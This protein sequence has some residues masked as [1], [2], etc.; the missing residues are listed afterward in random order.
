MTTSEALG[1]I[2]HNCLGQWLHNIAAAKDGRD[3]EGVHQLRIAARRCRSALSLFTEAIGRDARVAWNDRL[4]AVI[5]TTGR[6]RELDVFLTETLPEVARHQT[7]EDEAALAAL[8]R[9]A[10][11]ERA[12]GYTEVRALLDSRAH[13]DLVLDLAIWV[14]LERWRED[15]S[16]DGRQI[17]ESPIIDLARRLLEKRH[18]RVRKLGRHFTR[19]S[20]AER[21]QVRLALKKLR[22]GVE[23]LG[24]L[25][26][27]R[28]AKRYGKAASALQD[29]LGQLN[30]RAETHVLLAGLGSGVADQSIAE[31]LDV[32]RGIGFMLGAQAGGL[33]AQRAA[34]EQAWEAFMAQPL[35]WHSS[36]DGT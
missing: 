25:F 21:H 1:E 20:D 7:G 30:D 12:A 15:A 10:E 27:G 14:A 4:K 6:A 13:A 32:Q 2:L 5:T 31:R 23:F 9:C 34:A 28:A 11:I 35:F 26:P 22:Y 8:A 29:V 17:L 24:G 18:K 3:V 33:T 19:L 16:E 36:G